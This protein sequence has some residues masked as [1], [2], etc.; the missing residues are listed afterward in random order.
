MSY[1]IKTLSSVGLSCDLVGA[2]FL[3]HDIIRRTRIATR[4]SELFTNFAN[5][6]LP[7]GMSEEFQLTQWKLQV[8]Q[9]KEKA[10][11]RKEEYASLKKGLYGLWV[12]AVGFALQLLAVL[13]S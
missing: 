1:L 2:G 9:S 7:P 4:M 8:A 5:Y 6:G 13:L 12:L 3:A 11:L 10:E